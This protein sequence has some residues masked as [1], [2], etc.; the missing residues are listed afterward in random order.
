MEGWT[1]EAQ[2]SAAH[3]IN[4][5]DELRWCLRNVELWP[6]NNE[7]L[8]AQKRSSDRMCHYILKIYFL[9]CVSREALV[10]AN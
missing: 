10:I 2:V 8:I 7:F 3:H 9:T 5:D 6:S 4:P 1:L